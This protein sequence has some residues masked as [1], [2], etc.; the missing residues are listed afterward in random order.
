[1]EITDPELNW[2]MDKEGTDPTRRSPY[3]DITRATY[4]TG[5]NT[6]T[7]TNTTGA[8]NNVFGGNRYATTVG[9]LIW[10][11]PTG[12]GLFK[13]KLFFAEKGGTGAV[14]GAG[15]RVFDVNAEGILAF[16]DVDIYAEAGM[17]AMKRETDVT[18]TDGTLDLEFIRNINN[19]QVNGIEIVRLSGA[20]ARVAGNI[21]TE[22][23]ASEIEL[24][25]NKSVYAYPN[26]IARTT[27]IQFRNPQ[28]GTVVLKVAG[29]AGNTVKEIQVNA[30]NTTII[31]LDLP[32]ETMA[33]GLYLLEVKTTS[34]RKVIKLFNP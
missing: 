6:W 34:G 17:A 31:P 2:G 8:P 13:V 15:Q 22:K 3:L 21:Q 25:S 9:P 5:S 26:P 11:F 32:I 4:T 10:H 27:F 24:Y 19:P 30:D 12:N 23:A 7:G 16:D 1:L 29:N 20:G 33:S 18:V 14:N 28:S